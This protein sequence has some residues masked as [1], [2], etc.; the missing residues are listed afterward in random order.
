MPNQP[1]KRCQWRR[2]E[3]LWHRP[4]RSTC[5]ICSSGRSLRRCSR[6]HPLLVEAPA[7]A[8]RP[9]SWRCAVRTGYEN[10]IPPRLAHSV[11]GGDMPQR[12][13]VLGRRNRHSAYPWG[14]V[15]AELRFLQRDVGNSSP[16]RPGG[17][18]PCGV[19]RCGAG[20]ETRRG[21]LRDP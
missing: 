12:R 2:P 5:A 7:L 6:E 4:A 10:P 9:S 21:D 16:T 15:H 14:Y 3:I 11:P 19:G 20:M 1:G 13:R 8:Y 18:F 17:A